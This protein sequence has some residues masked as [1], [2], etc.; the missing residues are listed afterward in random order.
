MEWVC[1]LCLLW[2]M[3]QMHSRVEMGLCFGKDGSTTFVSTNLFFSYCFL[4]NFFLVLCTLRYSRLDIIY[5]YIYHEC[6]KEKG[7]KKKKKRKKVASK[8]PKCNILFIMPLETITIISENGL[9]A[10]FVQLYPYSPVLF[11]L[12]FKCCNIIYDN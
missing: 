3:C 12:L 6:K 5:I 4:L 10:A 7:L 1:L 9:L 2:P 8:T 11:V